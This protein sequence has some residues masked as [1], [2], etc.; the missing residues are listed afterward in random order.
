VIAIKKPHPARS[1]KNLNL[2]VSKIKALAKRY[3]ISIRSFSI[4]VLERLLLE[5]EKPNRRNLA[6]KVATKYPAIGYELK[7]EKSHKNSYH[8]RMCEAVALGMLLTPI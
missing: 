8:L 1:S 4:N 3:R 7:A 6:E 2:L 5:N